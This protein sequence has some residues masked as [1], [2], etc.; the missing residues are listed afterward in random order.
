MDLLN[1]FLEVGD[2]V[3]FVGEDSV[4]LVGKVVGIMGEWSLIG[5][6]NAMYFL[7]ASEVIRIVKED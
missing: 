4:L 5:E 2:W 7:H 6:E 3:A 1:N